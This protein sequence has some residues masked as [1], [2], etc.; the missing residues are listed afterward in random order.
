MFPSELMMWIGFHLVV[1]VMLFIDSIPAIF[2]ITTDTF[3]VYTSNVFAI[4]GLRALYFLLN[5]IMGLFRY[6]KEGISIILIFVGVKMIIV[7]F[8]QI[9]ILVSLGVIV[10]ILCFS[11]LASWIFPEKRGRVVWQK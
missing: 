2:A 8:Y 7:D 9:P 11:I 10:L 1:A 5:G 4:L 3:I 6:L